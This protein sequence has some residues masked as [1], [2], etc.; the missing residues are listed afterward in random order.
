M[1]LTKALQRQ[2]GGKDG[3]GRSNNWI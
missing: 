3:S 2:F 1:N